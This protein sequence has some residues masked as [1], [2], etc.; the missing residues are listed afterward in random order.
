MKWTS[1]SSVVRLASRKARLLALGLSLAL[2]GLLALL[3]FHGDLSP[4][5][6]ITRLPESLEVEILT[7]APDEPLPAA[8]DE[9]S[10]PE[11]PAADEA[12]H[13][14]AA[15][16]EPAAPSSAPE[17]RARRR[18]APEG[19]DPG[20][21]AER[22]PEAAAPG[23]S[24]LRMRT[25]PGA[26]DLSLGYDRVD[27]MTREGVIAPP[28]PTG[29]AEGRPSRPPTFSQRLAARVRNDAARANVAKGEVHPQ[30]YDLL[31]DARKGFRPSLVAL[32]RDRRAPN[33]V[34]RTLKQWFGGLLRPHVDPEDERQQ[35]PD[36]SRAPD[37]LSEQGRAQMRAMGGYLGLSS[38][39][40]SKIE[41]MDCVVCVVLR[42]DTAPEVVLG[43]SSGNAELDNAAVE[44]LK[45]ATDNRAIE[46]DVPSQ[47]SCYR[48]RATV[49]RIP[50]VPV[51]GCGFDEVTMSAKCFYPTQKVHKT[52]VILESV[53][54]GG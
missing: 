54:Y 28:D 20:A 1:L 5:G 12:A 3:L 53:D 48:F 39:R 23:R 8:P 25:G 36:Q 16:G 37:V 47:K 7:P 18:S 43:E 21:P 46:E 27:R 38:G 40:T 41:P 51:I 44:A 42:P 10:P 33:T 2:H 9:P 29:V 4:S 50:P 14:R 52:T 49:Q 19:A 11:S 35:R 24:T 32:E 30:M 15:L 17:P 34:G 13:D 45:Q 26:L 22:P 31:R 6:S